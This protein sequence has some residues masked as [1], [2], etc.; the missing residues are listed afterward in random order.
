MGSYYLSLQP[1]FAIFCW[2]DYIVI[3][4]IITIACQILADN[5]HRIYFW[6]EVNVEESNIRL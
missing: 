1:D 5:Q 2:N 6:T 4:N 3:L